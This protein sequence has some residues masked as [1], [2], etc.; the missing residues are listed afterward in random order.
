MSG[1]T[2]ILPAPTLLVHDR[3]S[4]RKRTSAETQRALVTRYKQVPPYGHRH[5][6]IPR[7]VDDYG[8]GGAFPEIH[9]AQYPLEI[10]R[11]KTE[12]SNALAVPV[13]D[14]G[15]IIRSLG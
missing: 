14:S 10:G 8:D 12:K 5:G 9:I 15:N 4:E 1:L 6:Y 11:R 2:S 3:D 13:D 7:N